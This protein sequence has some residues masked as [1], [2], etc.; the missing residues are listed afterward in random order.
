MVVFLWRLFQFML[1]LFLLQC[2]SL[3][4]HLLFTKTVLPDIQQAHTWVW[5][6]SVQCACMCLVSIWIA[7]VQKSITSVR[8]GFYYLFLGFLLLLLLPLFV[9]IMGE[10]WDI[11][12]TKSIHINMA[13]YTCTPQYHIRIV[14]FSLNSLSWR[15]ESCS[16]QYERASAACLFSERA[17]KCFA[18]RFSHIV[19]VVI[20]LFFFFHFTFQQ[21]PT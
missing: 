7:V 15:N 10:A 16:H 6:V 4:C 2:S 14:S 17:H 19:V 18:L 5:S 1:V 13:P 21:F 8:C 12:V 9:G 3:V 11:I 20:F